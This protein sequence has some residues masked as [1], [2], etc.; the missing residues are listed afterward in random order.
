MS[1]LN[2]EEIRKRFEQSNSFNDIFEAFE[3]AMQKR[4]DDIGLY[5][6]LFWNH[7]LTLE[8]IC[9]FG[10]HLA[11]QIPAVA[12]DSYMWLANVFAITQSANDNFALAVK[13]YQKAASSRPAETSPYLDAADCYNHDLNIPSMDVLIE[14][15]KKGS[16][17]V[18]APKPLFQRLSIF[19]ELKG[20]D[21]MSQFYRRKAGTEPPS[22][23][24]S[25]STR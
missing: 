18:P 9:M 5:R 1:D 7:T 10:E 22:F 3:Q 14:F 6:S 11:E 23:N 8:E 15:L 2:H 21:E 4:I 25:R 12:Y 13:Y 17:I 24:D 16:E 19:F 20:N